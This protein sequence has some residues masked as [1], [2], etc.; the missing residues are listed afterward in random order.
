MK[1]KFFVIACALLICGLS[2]VLFNA[3]DKDTNCYVKVTVIDENN[4]LPVPGANIKIDMDNSYV[5]AEG[6]TDAAGSFSAT[7]S[8]PAIFNVA[9]SYVAGYD[10][11]YLPD[12]T[13]HTLI[14]NIYSLN[15]KGNTTV[16]LK[17]GETITTSVTLESAITRERIF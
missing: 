12:D 1:K 11:T 7:F 15:R 3:C 4:N 2:A 6:V 17:E 9:A 16:R 13:N 14:D 5:N 8:A 10:T